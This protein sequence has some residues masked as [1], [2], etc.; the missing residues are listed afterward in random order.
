MMQRLGL[1]QA[2]LNDPELI[3]LDEPTDGVD[4]IGRKEIRDIL[5]R[6]REEGKTIF[7]NSHLLSEVELI[8]DRVGILNKGRLLKEG[9]VKELTERK[10]EFIISVEGEIPDTIDHF[11]IT[12][13]SAGQY[14]VKV[15]DTAELNHI[16]DL[17]R[18]RG[19]LVKEF[20]QQKNTLEDMFISLIKEA[21]GGVR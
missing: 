18:N 15:N 5:I 4:P 3:F 10:Q 13:A 9:T 16:L 6:L 14:L 1:A 2:L 17:L 7:L 8:T 20:H 19:I 12:R 11:H 21:D